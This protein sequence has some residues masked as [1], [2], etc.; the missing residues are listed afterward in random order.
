MLVMDFGES[1]FGFMR[2]SR[3]GA[4]KIL[5]LYNLST[6]PQRVDWSDCFPGTRPL[7]AVREL[8]SNTIIEKSADGILLPACHANWMMIKGGRNSRK[9]KG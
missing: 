9:G 7:K 6:E 5:C 3:T 1:I 2:V 4:E 8:L